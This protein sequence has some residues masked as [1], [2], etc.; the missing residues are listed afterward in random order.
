M[1]T[2]K[3]WRCL[4]RKIIELPDWLRRNRFAD[5]PLVFSLQQRSNEEAIFR[6]IDRTPGIPFHIKQRFFAWLG[7][8]QNQSNALDLI[9][10]TSEQFFL[11]SHDHKQSKHWRLSDSWGQNYKQLVQ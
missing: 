1:A 7:S 3:I 2:K 6:E 11:N 8:L 4:P 5:C 9:K 10:N